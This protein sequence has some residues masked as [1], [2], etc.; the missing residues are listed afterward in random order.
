MRLLT[1]IVA[2]VAALYSGYWY[3]GA[4]AVENG[5][6]SA[7]ESARADGWQIAYDEL[8]TR[9]FPSRFDTTLTNL[10]V[11]APDIAFA[12]KTPIFQALALSYAPNEVILAFSDNHEL[13]LGAQNFDIQTT[14]MRASAAVSATPSA[15]L[16]SMTAEVGP[17]TISAERGWKTGV[18]KALIALRPVAGEDTTYDAYLNTEEL[19]IP[20][21]LQALLET[22]GA[23]APSLQNV[24][25]DVR[26]TLDRVLDR[27]ALKVAETDPP[28][29]QSMIL[30]D[31][32]LNWGDMKFDAT[33]KLD[34]DPNGIPDGTIHISA[35]NWK[36]IISVLAE[37]S[38]IDPG[39]APLIESVAGNL[40]QSQERL[41]LPI[42]FQNG[43]TTIG[44]WP[45]GPAPR[46]F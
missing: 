16:Q 19:R 27:H 29:P 30:R 37:L 10:D 7:V 1:I 8:N 4:R 24:T 44:P 25:F 22:T 46:F 34:F 15:S 3:V 12:Y 41:E 32:T 26:V 9:G 6:A 28:R 45:L 31:A 18:D 23:I 17:V 33:G 21:I 2:T 38:V 39:M 36:Q 20:D 5:S 11:A 43:Q 13:Q 14:A 35:A 42:S 40:A